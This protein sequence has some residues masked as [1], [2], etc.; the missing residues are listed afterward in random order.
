[1]EKA[2]QLIKAAIGNPSRGLGLEL[3]GMSPSKFVEKY[4][5]ELPQPD[6]NGVPPTW[7][8]AVLSEHVPSIGK[9]STETLEA[10]EFDVLLMLEQIDH[11]EH[12]VL[13]S[14][15][16]RIKLGDNFGNMPRD[17]FCLDAHE[18]ERSNATTQPRNAPFIKAV[19]RRIK[20]NPNFAMGVS[21]YLR[22]KPVDGWRF[23]GRKKFLRKITQS[24]ENHIIIGPRRVG[25]S[26]LMRESYRQLKQE[27]QPVYYIDVR[28]CERPDDVVRELMQKLSTSDQAQV[29]Y[30]YEQKGEPL[31]EG[32]L[33]RLGS[34]SRRT[35]LL[36]DELGPVLDHLPEKDSF[37]ETLRRFGQLANFKIAFSCFE[38]SIR[39]HQKEF[40]GP[41]VN[42][43]HTLELRLFDE[44]EVR[45]MVLGPLEFWK[46]LQD[47]ERRN[48]MELVFTEIGCHP[49]FLQCFCTGMFEA[50]TEDD[51]VDL[52]LRARAI[53]DH[54]LAEHF[55]GEVNETFWTKTTKLVKYLY[56]KH[57]HQA[58]N[59]G[60]TQLRLAT[61][62][63]DWVERE[64]SE[65]G[66][67]SD[68]QGR[69]D[70]M[71]NLVE[72]GLHSPLDYAAHKLA[73]ATPVVYRHLKNQL[74]EVEK[75]LPKLEAEVRREADA[76]NARVDARAKE[77]WHG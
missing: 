65:L 20:G 67:R 68:L 57:C 46:P 45:E 59:E 39:R 41:M 35:T 66:Y 44:Q 1:M 6:F 51:C 72:H 31:L 48:L 2:Q 7:I 60:Q 25:K 18:M 27:G 17:V 11:E 76:W 73:I 24:S 4:K 16:P 75:F 56:L 54:D 32:I 37:L 62:D 71:A 42:F 12:V 5:V 33:Q 29:K 21:P 8:F 3:S 49:L 22:Q 34:R 52:S 64:L 10:I 28:S 15:Y 50:M 69:K 30:H 23:F 14:P 26:S 61:I 53:L 63:D 47:A 55:A 70:L 19:R 38:E 58:E 43:G 13:I 36:L 40:T 77:G 9:V 74:G